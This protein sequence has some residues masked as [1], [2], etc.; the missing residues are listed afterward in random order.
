MKEAIY[1]RDRGSTPPERT[2]SLRKKAEAHIVRESLKP[3]G[4]TPSTL[5]GKMAGWQYRDV[6]V[7]VA[8]G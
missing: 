3:G 8:E 4:D 7:L 5:I 1:I 2:L 6:P